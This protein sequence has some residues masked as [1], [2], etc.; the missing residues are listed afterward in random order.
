MG[1]IKLNIFK[2]SNR[3]VDTQNLG[4][5]SSALF[6]V[7]FSIGWTPCVGAFLGSALILASQQAH[8]MEGMLMLFTYSIG[9]GVP[10]VL[11]AILIDKL[12]TTFDW[13]KR[14][15]K[16]INLICGGFLIITGIMMATGTLG[17]LLALLS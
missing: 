7:I 2:G 6:G 10:F 13:I 12:K 15:Y 8:A 9:L 5:F 1:V 3:S 17:R 4:F 14:N 16:I 11:S